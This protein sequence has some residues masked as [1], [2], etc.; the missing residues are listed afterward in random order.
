M[1]LFFCKDSSNQGGVKL[2][3]ASI[4]SCKYTR[5]QSVVPWTTVSES[6]Q[7]LLGHTLYA[8]LLSVWPTFQSLMED[9]GCKCKQNNPHISRLLHLMVPVLDNSDCKL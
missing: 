8:H 9:V 3:T 1:L 7:N 2:Y 4:E 5:K 6:I